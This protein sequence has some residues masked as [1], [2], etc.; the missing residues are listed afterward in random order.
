M[1]IEFGKSWHPGK[2]I[3]GD[4]R[5]DFTEN[6]WVR[7]AAYFDSPPM[8]RRGFWKTRQRVCGWNYRIGSARHALTLLI[9]YR[10]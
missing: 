10:F 4:V 8:L 6:R 5:V 3:G 1:T 9:H 2:Q 7:V